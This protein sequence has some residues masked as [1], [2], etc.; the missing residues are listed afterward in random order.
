[1]KKCTIKSV[2][3][4]WRVEIKWLVSA[5]FAGLYQT[6]GCGVG[7]GLADVLRFEFAEDIPAVEFD[8]INRLAHKISDLFHGEALHGKSQH[9]QFLICKIT[10]IPKF[11]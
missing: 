3:N 5:P 2:E 6:I 10:F 8:S 7:N 11:V 9:F 4:R 1:M